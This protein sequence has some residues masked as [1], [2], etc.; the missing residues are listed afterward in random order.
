MA[1]VAY[2][3][4][5]FDLRGGSDED[6]GLKPPEVIIR[7][8]FT[9]AEHAHVQMSEYVGHPRKLRCTKLSLYISPFVEP[10]PLGLLDTGV[11]P[12]RCLV[13]ACLES[14]VYMGIINFRA[15]ILVVP[16]GTQHA[17][18]CTGKTAVDPKGLDLI[19]QA[20]DDQLVLSV[21][22]IPAEPADGDL[23]VEPRMGSYPGGYNAPSEG[24][25]PAVQ[26]EKVG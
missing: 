24:A 23:A 2:A 15:V 22:H 11:P 19:V 6:A 8:W 4:H 9:K 17:H 14:E 25:P 5:G 7:R 18:P 1:P 26:L 16:S 3:L 10:R 12:M 21:G 13:A 20:E